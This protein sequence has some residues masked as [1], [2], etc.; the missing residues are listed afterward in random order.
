MIQER[1]VEHRRRRR[2]GA[3]RDFALFVLGASGVAHEE[4]FTSAARPELL[5][6]YLAMMIGAAGLSDII[7]LLRRR[8]GLRE[9]DE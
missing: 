6:V 3:L 2:R 1:H 9:R 5:A 4:L 8:L 7:D